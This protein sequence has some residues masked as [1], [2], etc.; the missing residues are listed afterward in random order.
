MDR[1]ELVPLG[2]VRPVIGQKLEQVGKAVASVAIE[3]DSEVRWAG[4]G[5]RDQ[6]GVCVDGATYQVAVLF[7]DGCS[8]LPSGAGQ[9]QWR[10]HRF[11]RFLPDS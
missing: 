7:E 5:L 10:A 1:A 11:P 4:H 2:G 9:N 6:R 8:V 3:R